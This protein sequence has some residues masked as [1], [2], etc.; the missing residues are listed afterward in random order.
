MPSASR[1]TPTTHA[2]GSVGVI[3]I[4]TGVLVEMLS[5]ALEFR[6]LRGSDTEPY[7]TVGGSQLVVRS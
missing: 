6:E 7:T 5:K 1:F 2:C 3:S 4:A